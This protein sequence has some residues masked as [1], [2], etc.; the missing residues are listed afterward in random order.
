MSKRSWNVLAKANEEE[1]T[2]LCSGT[3]GANSEWADPAAA[4]GADD[5]EATTA[6]V[7][8]SDK[9]GVTAPVFDAVG[10]PVTPIP[11]PHPGG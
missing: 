9:L 3:R 4:A 5:D 10:R 11:S 8:W 6:A 1:A 7:P 2:I